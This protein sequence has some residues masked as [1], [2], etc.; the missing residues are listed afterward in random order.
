MQDTEKFERFFELVQREANKRNSVFFVNAGDGHEAD[1]DT[2]TCED[3][4]GWL[5]PKERADEFEKIWVKENADTS[6]W[7]EE[8]FC[9]AV[10]TA[11]E[12]TVEISFE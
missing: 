6:K 1:I 3:L 11:N 4:S 7:D 12:E 9:F 10:W 2:L 5:I 8:F